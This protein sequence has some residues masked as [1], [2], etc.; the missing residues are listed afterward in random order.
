MSWVLHFLAGV[1]FRTSTQLDRRFGSV[2][3]PL[4]FRKWL[5]FT[6]LGEIVIWLAGIPHILSSWLLIFLL[7]ASIHDYFQA[8]SL[9]FN[10]RLLAWWGSPLRK[11]RWGCQRLLRLLL[12]YRFHHEILVFL[13]LLLLHSILRHG[14][15]QLRRLLGTWLLLHA[16]C[17]ISYIG[18]GCG[19]WF[20][21]VTF[22]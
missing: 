6:C 10:W 11:P 19:I 18:V 9:A 16:G 17:C 13:M 4:L 12:D 14:W 2:L 22:W 20:I 5:S 15:R 8:L 3:S 1:C 21:V 7:W